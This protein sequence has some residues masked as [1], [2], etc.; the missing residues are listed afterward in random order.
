MSEVT[1]PDFDAIKARQQATWATGDYAVIAAQVQ[2][3]SEVLCETVDIRAGSNVLDVAC[4]SGSGNASLSA[5]R[6]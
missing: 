6:T 4:G 2:F 5:A 1:T 3:V